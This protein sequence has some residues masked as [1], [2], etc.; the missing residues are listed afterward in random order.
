MKVELGQLQFAKPHH[1]ARSLQFMGIASKLAAVLST[2]LAASLLVTTPALGRDVQ[3]LEQAAETMAFAQKSAAV[4]TSETIEAIESAPV[5][6]TALFNPELDEM[7][8][9]SLL[10]TFYLSLPLS[11]IVAIW[12]Y[13][14][15][16]CEQMAKL[17]EQVATLERIWQHPQV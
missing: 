14:R 12:R 9:S 16:A 13:D 6:R 7:L 4:K 11:V 2:G 17:L 10:W 5:K 15:R 8:S 1:P 3:P